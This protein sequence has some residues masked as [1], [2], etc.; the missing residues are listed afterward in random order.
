MPLRPRP[1]RARG[2]VARYRDVVVGIVAS[3]PLSREEAKGGHAARMST[4]AGARARALTIGVIPLPTACPSCYS[5]S[6][7]CRPDATLIRPWTGATVRG[8]LRYPRRSRM[9]TVMPAPSPPRNPALRS[10]RPADAPRRA[11][12]PNTT[13]IDRS[14]RA[15]NGSRIDGGNE[16]GRRAG[17]RSRCAVM[18]SAERR[19]AWLCLSTDTSSSGR[20]P[21]HRAFCGS[22]RV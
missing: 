5:R 2:G 9:S 15:A 19:G 4:Q 7:G 17:R 18:A 20:C 16:K 12:A 3:P 21:A 6:R 1:S 11:V 22:A 10:R 13:P 8:H 14:R